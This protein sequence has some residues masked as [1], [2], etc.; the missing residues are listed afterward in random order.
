MKPLPLPP[1][2]C[3]VLT[4]VPVET[5]VLFGDEGLGPW[6]R[7]SRNPLLPRPV[8][9]PRWRFDCPTVYPAP[10]AVWYGSREEVGAFFETFG[11]VDGRFVTPAQRDDKMLGVFGTSR[12]LHLLDV[13]PP[14]VLRIMS[15]PGLDGRFDSWPDYDLTQAW[16][17][18]FHLCSMPNKL[19]GLLYRGRKAGSDCIALF[20][21]RV[22]GA[23]KQLSS[24][25]SV[26][27][28]SLKPYRDAF[29]AHTGKAWA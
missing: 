12:T 4:L 14:A 5:N 25:V 26:D 21:A 9:D 29:T 16:S 6:Y 8:G 15:T 3:S 20:H 17:A 10:Y 11:E 24:P 13:R 27:D 22:A 18:A 2:D 1:D 7:I 19:D 28:S 23:L